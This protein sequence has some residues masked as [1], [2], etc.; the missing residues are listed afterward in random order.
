MEIFPNPTRSHYIHDDLWCIVT[1]ANQLPLCLACLVEHLEDESMTVVQKQFNLALLADTVK[2][3]C[4]EVAHLLREHPLVCQHIL[5]IITDQYTDKSFQTVSVQ[6]CVQ[7]MDTL[8]SEDL[9]VYLLNIFEHQVQNDHNAVPFV[10]AALGKLS[11][12]SSAYVLT[13]I[14]SHEHLLMS[15][16][17]THAYRDSHE[18]DASDCSLLFLLIRLFDVD[19]LPAVPPQ[20]PPLV[21]RC[22]VTCISSSQSVDLQTNALAL[23]KRLASTECCLQE[24]SG[25]WAALLIW[26]KRVFVGKKEVLVTAAAQCLAII[27]SN[28]RHV[29]VVRLILDSDLPEFLFES[30]HT[31]NIAQLEAIFKCLE[32]LAEHDLFFRKCHAVYGLESILRSLDVALDSHN[33]AVLVKGFTLL[34]N[35]LQ[36]Q[37]SGVP[38]CVNTSST[39]M[40]L[41]VITKGAQC[42]ALQVALPAITAA[43]AL[44]RDSSVVGHQ[45]MKYLQSLV[46]A[47]LEKVGG[48]IW[49][50]EAGSVLASLQV[51]EQ[52]LL[53]T[54]MDLL[55]AIIKLEIEEKDVLVTRVLEDCHNIISY[56]GDHF[57]A[58]DRSTLGSV[59]HFLNSLYESQGRDRLQDLSER[60]VSCGFIVQLFITKS[61]FRSNLDLLSAA[62]SFA[63]NVFD[64]LVRENVPQCQS[65]PGPLKTGLRNLSFKGSIQQTVENIREEEAADA[66]C[67]IFYFSCLNDAQIFSASH[68]LYAVRDLHARQVLTCASHKPLTSRFLLYVLAWASTQSDTETDCTPEDSTVETAVMQQV[69]ELPVEVWATPRPQLFLW[70]F[71]SPHRAQGPGAALL[72]H[73]LLHT[74]GNIPAAD[75]NDSSQP[76]VM[77]TLLLGQHFTPVL[78]GLITSQSE[79][80]SMLAKKLFVRLISALEM[81]D[82]RQTA[83][84]L[85]PSAYEGV[86]SVFQDLFINT[87]HQ[88]R[89][90][91][92]NILGVMTSLLHH[93]QYDHTDTDHNKQLR[94]IYHGVHFLSSTDEK[95][96]DII[97][98]GIT[99]L[100]AL[101]KVTDEDQDKAIVP[102]LLQNSAFLE[103]L[104]RCLQDENDQLSSAALSLVS[105]VTSACPDSSNSNSIRVSVEFI[106]NT[107]IR[108]TCEN[109]EAALRM[110][111]LALDSRCSGVSAPVTFHRCRAFHTAGS[112]FT[113]QELRLLFCH[114][115]QYVCS[116]NREVQFCAVQCYLKLIQHGLETDDNLGE[117]FLHHPWNSQLLYYLLSHSSTGGLHL[118]V[119]ELITQIWCDEDEGN[120]EVAKLVL[121][122]VLANEISSDNQDVMMVLVQK[123]K[124]LCTDKDL[125]EKSICKLAS[126]ED[127]L[128]FS[129]NTL[130]SS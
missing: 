92:K 97:F 69:S 26:F 117:H 11:V 110:L 113:A 27:A 91:V 36:R 48:A 33:V 35:I 116:E 25:S 95:D 4:Y 7:L 15:L 121:E 114:M 24:D 75:S 60:V 123:A 46:E 43:T 111:H 90:V 101:S 1:S 94:V 72:E 67:M 108:H 45:P 51:T 16:L 120:A 9:Y 52:Q 68:I 88:S 115:Q 50:G 112:P 118:H 18:D 74:K 3:E 39:E 87:L 57:A 17:G 96:D 41:S 82:E 73:W 130:T 55:A 129:Q 102:V 79:E 99:W 56:V 84:Q 63:S 119:A 10:V 86:M 128:S 37:P 77:H 83:A 54:L 2:P 29:N 34:A 38:V 78:L 20:A 59:L 65:L 122:S 71:H 44:L 62:A 40:T 124:P 23:L 13:L 104:E 109:M 5:N 58:C 85:I 8:Q 6:I 19:I 61:E 106:M 53:E 21:E 47:G 32:L 126:L 100:H 28:P 49:R 107:L 103:Q 127:S 12:V 81:S 76:H 125:L 105:W 42:H 70:L 89:H 14:L 30:L 80:I 22:L 93:P 98:S 31:L 66:L 64:V